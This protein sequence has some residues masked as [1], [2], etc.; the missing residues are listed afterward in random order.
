ML[1]KSRVGC[2]LFIRGSWRIIRQFSCREFW[3]RRNLIGKLG[4]LRPI[5][6]KLLF[7]RNICYGKEIINTMLL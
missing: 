3:K 5:S 1:R 4:L 7:I 2:R 6:F